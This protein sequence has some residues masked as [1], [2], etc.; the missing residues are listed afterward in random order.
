MYRVAF[1]FRGFSGQV[2]YSEWFDSEFEAIEFT[3]LS[4][5]ADELFILLIEDENNK[6]V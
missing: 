2:Y 3:K 6:I 4:N 1:S 5:D